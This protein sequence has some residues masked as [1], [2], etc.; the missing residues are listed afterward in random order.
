[1]SVM[2]IFALLL[3]TLAVLV[4]HLLASGLLLLPREF[5]TP[6]FSM[7]W[8]IVW[9]SPYFLLAALSILLLVLHAF[10]DSDRHTIGRTVPRRL[11]R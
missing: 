8:P 5:P 11:Q 10:A 7:A 4:R 3:L 9:L 2:G 1:M 6:P